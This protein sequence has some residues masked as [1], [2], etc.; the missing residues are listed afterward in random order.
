[1]A[2]PYRDEKDKRNELYLEILRLLRL[3][4]PSYFL[5]ENVKGLL[6]MGGYDSNAD[7]KNQLGKVMKVIL[8]DLGE[9]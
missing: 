3:K 7:K 2:N 6:N 5:L 4:K 1:M 8:K 9:C